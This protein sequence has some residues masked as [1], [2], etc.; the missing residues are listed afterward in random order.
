MCLHVS[1]YVYNVYSKLTELDLYFQVPVA[2]KPV[3]EKVLAVSIP[4]KKDSPAPKGRG[5]KQHSFIFHLQS[6][7]LLL[8]LPACILYFWHFAL[9]NVQFCY[10][11]PVLNIR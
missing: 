7:I 2:K 4:E 11:F 10:S 3:E 6:F 9:F 5:A 8:L 1:V